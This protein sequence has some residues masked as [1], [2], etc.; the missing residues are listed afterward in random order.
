MSEFF[1]DY[2]CISM[3]ETLEGKKSDKSLN[4]Y[5]FQDYEDDSMCVQINVPKSMQEKYVLAKLYYSYNDVTFPSLSS[6]AE[7]PV[8]WYS[9]N[10]DGKKTAESNFIDTDNSVFLRSKEGELSGCGVLA[11]VRKGEETKEPRIDDCF[12]FV[13]NYSKKEI[14]SYRIVE[15]KSRI[16]VEVVYPLIKSDVRLCIVQKAGAKPVLEGDRENRL[17]YMGKDEEA[18]IVL[19]ANG[20][21]ADVFKGTFRVKDASRFDYRLSFADESD[22]RYYLLVDESDYT[23]EDKTQRTIERVKKKIVSTGYAR[24]PYCGGPLTKYTKYKKGET[25]IVG[26]NGQLLSNFA[27]DN[28]LK[29]KLTVVCCADLVRQSSPSGVDRGYVEANNLILPENYGDRP[30]MNLV[31]G[32]F[33]KS[34][35][36]I[37]LSS[38]FNMSNGG[39]ERGITSYPFIL[40]K[41]VKAYDVKGKGEKLAEEVKFYNV[42]MTK[43]ERSDVCERMRSSPREDIKRRYVMSVGDSVEGQTAKSDAA[44]LSWNPIGYEM[45]N[46]GYIYFYD[47]PGECFT[48]DN[49]SEV[50]ALDMADCILAVINGSNEVTDPLGELMIT[51]ER[52]PLLSK[53]N[54]DM[55]N[56]PI[57]I[58][59]TKHDMKLVDYV[60]DKSQKEYCF[61]PNCH[62]VREDVIG[63]LPKNGVYEGSALERHI[64]CSSYELEHYLKARDKKDNYKRLKEK[65][66][67]VKFFTCSALG[68]DACLGKPKDGTKEVLFRPRRLRVEL[69]II[70]LMYKKGLIGR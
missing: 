36:T 42:D 60:D 29:G 30:S 40:N 7:P 46:L 33:P 3:G 23:M 35:K 32:G 43:Y 65:Y 8:I 4:F 69:P 49:R 59:F 34:G 44:K 9:D 63:M 54:F 52:I 2:K 68:S 24:C 28:R 56:I 11:F 66:K 51:L 6:P 37:Y 41:I 20:R 55:E 12:K 16:R 61:D 58:V 26:C 22:G 67:N 64:D 25:A 10:R 70:W 31:V 47:I 38:L 48:Q 17:K 5:L 14:I 13:I 62:V 39:T 53:K 27:T 19:K 21:V 15:S 50:R 45:G 18:S 57:A 1:F